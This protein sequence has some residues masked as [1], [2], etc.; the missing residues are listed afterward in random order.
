ML[1]I[2]NRRKTLFN[3]GA[4]GVRNDLRGLASV[5]WMRFDDGSY[6]EAFG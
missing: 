5:V 3:R 6:S 2:D 1:D 4:Q